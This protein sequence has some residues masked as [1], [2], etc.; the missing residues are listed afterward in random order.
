MDTNILR[1]DFNGQSVEFNFTHGNVM[2]NATQMAKLF[3]KQVTVFLRSEET[4]SFIAACLRSD[5]CH[6]SNVKT[7]EQLVTINQRNGTFMHRVLALKFAAW[8]DPD[9]ELWV[10]STIDE[11]LFGNL[12]LVEKSLRESAVRK[13]KMDALLEELGDDP[14]FVEL[15]TLRLQERQASYGRGK[16]A[17]QQL[18]NFRQTAMDLE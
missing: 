10:F 7:E 18:Q 11:I 12:R 16:H 3:D 1:Y 17:R 5:N 13:N 4:K 9:F 8:L 14:R 6:F 2:V 15:E